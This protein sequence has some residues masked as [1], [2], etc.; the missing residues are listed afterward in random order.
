ML[1]PKSLAA[2]RQMNAQDRRT[3]RV[4]SIGDVL[5]SDLRRTRRQR[6]STIARAI[7]AQL[8]LF[9]NGFRRRRAVRV[10][11]LVDVDM[12][13]TP[14]K[15]QASAAAEDFPSKAPLRARSCFD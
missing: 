6:L 10:S 5:R 13:V 11:T 8:S 14:G 3:E 15:P 7:A 4:Y 1:E 9:C 2:A 12:S